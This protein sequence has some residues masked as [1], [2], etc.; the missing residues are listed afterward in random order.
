MPCTYQFQE[1]FYILSVNPEERL[2]IVNE[3]P[4]ETIE[5]A[6]LLAGDWNGIC[7]I[8]FKTGRIVSSKWL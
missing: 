8:E 5:R 2:E 6:E 7:V 4:F 1:G 3:G